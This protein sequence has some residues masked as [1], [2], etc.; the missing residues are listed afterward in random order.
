MG[1]LTQN[2]YLPDGRPLYITIDFFVDSIATG[3]ACFVC[4]RQPKSG[5]RFTRE[6]ILPRWLLKNFDLLG[7]GNR[8]RILLGN[9]RRASHAQYTVPCCSKC[10]ALLGADIEQPIRE[11]FRSSFENFVE[12]VSQNPKIFDKLYCWLSL[13]LFK[14]VYKD[15]FTPRFDDAGQ[16]SGTVGEGRDWE[17]FHH[18]NSIIRS[19]YPEVLV[20]PEA[21]GSILIAKMHQER[22]VGNFSYVSFAQ[23]Q[24]IFLQFNDMGIFAFFDDAGLSRRIFELN[25]SKPDSSQPWYLAEAL[26]V[27]GHLTVINEFL[28]FR[29]KFGTWVDESYSRAELY[30]DVPRQLR[31][32]FDEDIEAHVRFRGRVMERLFEDFP[33]YPSDKQLLFS[34]TA[35]L[36]PSFGWNS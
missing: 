7:P 25:F 3:S 23:Q 34:G 28:E 10:N 4:S 31:T 32:C 2:I 13:L 35:S 9:K 24:C 19:V 12:T 11:L 27:F 26:E 5:E 29:P 18:L 17:I 8:S 15:R 36:L 1:V 6:H 16:Y 21:V 30:A 22:P 20:R 14:S 33:L